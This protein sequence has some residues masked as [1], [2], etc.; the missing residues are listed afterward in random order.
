L[1][2]LKTGSTLRDLQHFF[3]DASEPTRCGLGFDYRRDEMTKKLF[4]VR[5][6]EYPED[7]VPEDIRRMTAN[8]SS[9]LENSY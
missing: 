8:T 6:W 2:H 9:I 3:V 4:V 1:R 5:V 7:E